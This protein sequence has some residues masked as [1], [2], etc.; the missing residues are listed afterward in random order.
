MPCSARTTRTR[1]LD[2]GLPSRVPARK[3]FLSPEHKAE[4]LRFAETY[5]AENR[6]FWRSVIF[7]D[8]TSFSSV[9]TP[10]RHCRRRTG[11]RYNASNICAT[12]RS[13]RVSQAMYGWMWYGGVG[14]LVTTEGNMNSCDYINILE[15]S[16]LPSVRT[17]AMVELLPIYMVQDRS[18]IHTSRI[19][20][21]WFSHHPKIRLLDWPPKGCDINPIEH[22]W[23]IMKREWE[24]EEKTKAEIIRKSN[25]VWEGFRRTPDICSKLVYSL[26]SRLQQVIDANGG[27]IKY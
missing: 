16:F 12:D 19:V 10:G 18:P 15:T 8:E 3:P 20:R 22:L 24:V 25:E 27:W 23:G 9:S 21:E 4:R 17:Y 26:P 2:A 14:E 13:G 5:A 11:E 7:T 6:D 1:L